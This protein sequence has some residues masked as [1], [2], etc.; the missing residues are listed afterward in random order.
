[1]ILLPLI[2]S[3]FIAGTALAES[4]AAAQIFILALGNSESF[5]RSL[6]SSLC[7]GV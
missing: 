1:M 4:S 3:F 7:T 2:M 5:D 6:V